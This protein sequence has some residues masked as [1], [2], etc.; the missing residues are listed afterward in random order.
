MLPTRHTS[1]S[2][3]ALARRAG[4]GD[5][6]AFEELFERH[7]HPT[8]R[9]ALHMLNGE[10]ELAEDA[11]QDAWVKIWR[12]LPDFRGDARVQTWLFK[13]VARQVLDARRRKRPVVVDDSLLQP[14]ARGADPALLVVDQELW[15]TLSSALAELPW[16]Q[17]GS[18]LLREFEGLSYA[19]IAR[20]LDTTPTV[21]RGQLH[22]ARQALAIR[23]E[24][25]R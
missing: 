16:R 13:I 1:A 20:I 9:Y 12:H 17:R 21:V 22:R 19:E 10:D 25:W 11:T 3:R 8:Y 5:T 18:W 4:M 24:Q 2:D 23:M 7:F 6:V 14:I 15:E